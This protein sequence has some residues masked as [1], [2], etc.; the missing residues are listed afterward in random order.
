MEPIFSILPLNFQ[1]QQKEFFF[2]QDNLR[3]S[4]KFDSGN[5]LKAERELSSPTVF[6]YNKRIFKIF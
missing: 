6:V 2:E 4:S 3:F 5:M 1:P